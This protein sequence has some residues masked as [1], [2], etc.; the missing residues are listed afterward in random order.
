MAES[1]QH[2]LKRVRPPRVKIT[3]DVE[4]GNA[5]EKKEL[6][7]VAGIIADV[8]GKNTD[9]LPKFKDRKFAEIDRDNFNDV[10]KGV[11][12]R[13]QFKVPNR[14]SGGEGEIACDLTFH[15]LDDFEPANVIQQVEPLRKLF[16]ARQALND[17]A[18]KLDGNDNL[19]EVLSQVLADSSQREKLLAELGAGD[20]AGGTGGGGESAGA[21]DGGGSDD[22]GGEQSDEDQ[23]SE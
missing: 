23:G 3:Y 9:L 12:P 6:P 22:T 20:D 21:S 14:L 15:S 7:F 16:E 18:A 8:A 2:T 10:M 5:I 19:D 17:L 13:A 11:A 1:V 4:I